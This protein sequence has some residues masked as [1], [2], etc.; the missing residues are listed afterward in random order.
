MEVLGRYGRPRSVI[1]EQACPA[2]RTLAPCRQCPRV[3]WRA[4][5]D[6]PVSYPRVVGRLLNRQRAIA[7]ASMP[8]CRVAERGTGHRS[9]RGFERPDGACLPAALSVSVLR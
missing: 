2:N 9:S 6:V 5:A 7:A 3:T 4:L 8:G 1:R